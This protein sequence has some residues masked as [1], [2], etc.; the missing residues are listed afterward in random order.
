MAVSVTELVKTARTIAIKELG[1]EGEF[2]LA[3]EVEVSH[4]AAVVLAHDLEVLM[5]GVCPGY[6]RLSR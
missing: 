1:Y 3:K 2:D 6:L 4:R 5:D